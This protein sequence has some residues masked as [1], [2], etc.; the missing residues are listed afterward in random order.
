MTLSLRPDP[1]SAAD[2]GTEPA[3]RFP[4]QPFE[5]LDTL[6]LEVGGSLCNLS[7][8]HCF[9]SS[10]PG[11]LR[12][13][14][15]SR[16]LVRQRV[17]EALE[18]GVREFYFT[19]GEPFM[20]PELIDMLADTIVFAPCTVLTNGVLLTSERVAA[21]AGLSESSRHSLEI[22]VSLDGPD[23]ASHDAFRGPG[24]FA[25][26]IDGMVRLARAGLLPIATATL[27]TGEDSLVVRERYDSMLREAGIPRPRIKL[28]PMF[29]LGREA[30]RTGGYSAE[31]TLRDLP[32]EGFDPTRLQCRSCRAV[33]ALGVHVCPLLV[34][35]P[36]GRMGDR[37]IDAAAPYPLRHGA[38]FTCY[39]TG[40]TCANG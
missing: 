25:R 17:A 32:A 4:L 33:T 7:C 2:A 31:D 9:V 39:V 1:R 23:S 30:A 5:H 10:G 29:R 14:L 6:W 21:L 13:P 20:N 24:S 36:L 8:T 26:A 22:R 34:D 40:M 38:C 19:G 12:H 3:S 27:N 37:L 15:M 28:L 18:L 16:A 35:E 11:D